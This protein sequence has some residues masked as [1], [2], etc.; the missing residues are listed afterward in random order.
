VGKPQSKK[1]APALQVRQDAS[2]PEYR[3]RPI[4]IH[5]MVAEA[6]LSPST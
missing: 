4:I 6:Q 2:R 3:P 5:K 1:H